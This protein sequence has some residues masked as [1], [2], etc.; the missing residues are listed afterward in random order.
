MRALAVYILA[1]MWYYEV[2]L[3][4]AILL[5]MQLYHIV[6]LISISLKTNDVDQFVCLICS[7][8][9][10]ETLPTLFSSGGFYVDSVGF[11]S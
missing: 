5:D 1:S 2:F 11:P 7:T 10:P 3:L 4:V 8:L 9:Y 6:V